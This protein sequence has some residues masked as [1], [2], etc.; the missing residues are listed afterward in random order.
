MGDIYGTRMVAVP[1]V[2][3]QGPFMPPHT[4]RRTPLHPAPG[5]RPRHDQRNPVPVLQRCP[6]D[7]P[8]GPPIFENVALPSPFFSTT[9]HIGGPIT[10]LPDFAVTTHFMFLF[11]ISDPQFLHAAVYATLCPCSSSTETFCLSLRLTRVAVLNAE[12]KKSHQRKAFLIENF[13]PGPKGDAPQNHK[14]KHTNHR[15]R[16]P[17][18]WLD[19]EASTH[20]CFGGQNKCLILLILNSVCSLLTSLPAF[21]PCCFFLHGSV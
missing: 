18:R 5:H 2:F 21:L 12:P 1:G 3:T 15:R 17:R 14:P 11:I 10:H 7:T 16:F 6:G 8:Y 9:S 13:P 20:Y 19:S 4:T